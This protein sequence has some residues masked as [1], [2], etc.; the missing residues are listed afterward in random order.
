MSIKS[1][2]LVAQAKKQNAAKLAAAFKS[3]DETQMAEAM[4]VFCSD[5]HAAVL[6][7]A[8][9]APLPL[10]ATPHPVGGY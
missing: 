1:K 9:P 6:A 8:L 4:S 5:V 7:Q 2:D 3:G 10:W